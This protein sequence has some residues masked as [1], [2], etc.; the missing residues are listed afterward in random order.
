M[1]ENPIVQ[2]NIDKLKGLGYHFIE[3]KE[4]MLACGVLGKGALAD[5]DDIVETIEGSIR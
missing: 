5:V 2:G 4:S 3:P 1:Y